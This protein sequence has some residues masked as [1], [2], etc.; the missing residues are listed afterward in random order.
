MPIGGW[1]KADECAGRNYR[2][3]VQSG[4]LLRGY[5]AEFSRGLTPIGAD[6]KR[7]RSK[8]PTKRVL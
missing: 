2:I 5:E 8:N 6:Q 3:F 4:K 7:E 1:S